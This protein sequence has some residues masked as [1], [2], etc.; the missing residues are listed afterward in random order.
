MKK[1]SP[2]NKKTIV[3]LAVV[4]SLTAVCGVVIYKLMPESQPPP[5]PSKTTS[6]DNAAYIASTEFANMPLDK[7]VDYMKKL[8]EN[9]NNTNPRETFAKLLPDERKK[10]MENMRPV[11]HEMMKQRVDQYFALK[12]KEE[13]DK[14]LDEEAERM[15]KMRENRDRNR[16]DQGG[17]NN[18]KAQNQDN[19]DK[20]QNDQPQRRRPSKEEM[21]KRIENESPEERA[22][23]AEYMRQLRARMHR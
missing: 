12:T 11:M 1:L 19:K 21:K 2:K 22:K 4:L 3:S 17:Q 20:G 8:R 5:D 13:R 15:K 23:T 6:L 14:F 18:D 9:G 10:V 7:R 16:G